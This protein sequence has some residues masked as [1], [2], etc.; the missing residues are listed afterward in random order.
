MQRVR[1]KS[2]WSLTTDGRYALFDA[3]TFDE[4]DLHDMLTQPPFLRVLGFRAAHQLHGKYAYRLFKSSSPDDMKRLVGFVNL[5]FTRAL[6]SLGYRC[7]PQT[8][9]IEFL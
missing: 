9:E 4:K 5:G 1:F 7:V 8:D 6:A 2:Y 3:S